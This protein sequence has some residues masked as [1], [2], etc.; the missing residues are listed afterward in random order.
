MMTS[1]R[2]AYVQAFT[3]RG[4]RFFY[5]RRPGSPRIRLPG[6]PGSAEFMKAYEAAL[7]DLPPVEIGA[8]RTKSGTIN[9]L[10]VRYYGSA[11]F[12]HAL[13]RATQ[14]YRR[15][16]I[17]RFREP[18][19]DRPVALL[20]QRHVVAILEQIKKPHARKSWLKAIR[21]LMKYAVQI[22]MIAK[23]PTVD[24]K[25]VRPPKSDGHKTWGEAQIEAFR[26]RHPLGTRP[27]L[28]LELL[29]NTVQRRGD[30]VR[31]GR[32]HIR[33]G[34][35][36]VVQRKTLVELS[37]PVL[38]E[39]AAAIAAMPAGLTFLVTGAGKPF[40]DAGFGNWFRECCDEAG[41]KGYSA[42]GLRKAGCVRLA[43]AGCT[44]KQIAAWSGHLT[45]GE[46][47]R[48]TRAADQKRLARAAADKLA[49]SSV[50]QDR[51][52]VSNRRQ[53]IENTGK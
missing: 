33:N 50:K 22:G 37:L 9:D 38:P 32:Q 41:L 45:L 28:A 40:S 14:K 19:G 11:E 36:H 49:T 20:E 34:L 7:A 17:E 25:L 5:F 16:I 8:S 4:R 6:V 12:T 43:E 26:D 27:R 24:I 23:D 31:M 29:L 3:A 1:I 18:R 35:I 46:V 48:Y 53:D 44:E 10:I 47:A 51:P 21:G 39:L 42:H 2:L 15:N 30:V 13:S 52:E